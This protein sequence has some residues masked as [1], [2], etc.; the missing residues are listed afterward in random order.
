P[1]GARAMA[2]FSTVMNA[3]AL[4]AMSVPAPVPPGALPEGIQLVARGE[5]TLLDLA[6]AL[7]R[8]C[9]WPLL[10]P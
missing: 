4:P 5:E 9:P 6:A 2:V 10:A 1:A 8:R 3:A 7:E